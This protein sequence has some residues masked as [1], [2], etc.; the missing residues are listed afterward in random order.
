[1]QATPGTTS[2]APEMTEVAGRR[3]ARRGGI[4]PRGVP[5]VADAW[6]ETARAHG[7]IE[8]DHMAWLECVEDAMIGSV[9]RRP[10][11]TAGRGRRR[12]ELKALAACELAYE[13]PLS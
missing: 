8:Q 9:P 3:A 1:M 7:A 11:L 2:R 4:L 5:L 13:T 12:K 6:A 10:L